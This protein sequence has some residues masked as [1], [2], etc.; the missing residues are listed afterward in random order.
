ME[1]DGMLALIPNT[2]RATSIPPA[3]LPFPSGE[4]PSLQ[5]WEVAEVSSS[6][7]PLPKPKEEAGALPSLPSL[8][9]TVSW[10]WGNSRALQHCSHISGAALQDMMTAAEPSSQALQLDET[11]P[12]E[13]GRGENPLCAYCWFCTLRLQMI[14]SLRHAR[15][16]SEQSQTRF[17]QFLTYLLWDC[18][19]SH[20]NPSP[21]DCGGGR[22]WQEVVI[23]CEVSDTESSQPHMPEAEEEGSPHSERGSTQQSEHSPAS[24]ESQGVIQPPVKAGYCRSLVERDCSPIPP[25]SPV[26]IPFMVPSALP[27]AN[28]PRLP[29]LPLPCPPS[30]SPPILPA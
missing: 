30:Q 13:R 15:K 12:G 16:S 24:L 5:S 25:F 20:H 10:G 11:R 27:A 17:P 18:I 21:A 19:R 1:A 14:Q 28:Y 2:M 4:K 9:P 6:A 29:P 3:V 7:L 26:L 8:F 23:S 22:G